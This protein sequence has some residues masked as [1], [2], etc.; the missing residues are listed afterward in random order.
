[1]VALWNDHLKS[2]AAD[3]NKLLPA[4]S[5]IECP[6][7]LKEDAFRATLATQT[8]ALHDSKLLKMAQDQLNLLRPLE[9]DHPN[10]R[11]MPGRSLW[12]GARRNGRLAVGVNW[13]VEEVVGFSPEKP[14]DLAAHASMI[15]EKLKS[16]GLG[17]QAFLRADGSHK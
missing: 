10:L 13:A 4:R 5:L 2:I 8:K 17:G 12:I 9:A 16:K 3:I 15:A 1:M 14:G 11:G 6:R 7:V